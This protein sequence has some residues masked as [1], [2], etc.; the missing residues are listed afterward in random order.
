MKIRDFQFLP[1]FFQT[2]NIL[3]NDKQGRYR[4]YLFRVDGTAVTQVQYHCRWVLHQAVESHQEPHHRPSSPRSAVHYFVY[5]VVIFFFKRC[6]LFSSSL[7]VVFCLLVSLF[8]M[9]NWRIKSIYI[10]NIQM[11]HKCKQVTENISSLIR[12]KWWT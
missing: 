8:L 6:S 11:E 9:V 4:M 12:Y 1:N 2:R 3:E 7:M 10:H 5:K